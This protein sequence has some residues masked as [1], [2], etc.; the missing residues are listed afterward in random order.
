MP[1]PDV[2]VRAVAWTGF[3]IAA[4]IVVVVCAVFLLLHLWRTPPGAD[5]LRANGHQ[6]ADG[7]F[8]H[9]RVRQIHEVDGDGL[10]LL[11]ESHVEHTRPGN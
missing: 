8:H 6:F 1:K 4:A 11:P 5:R 3:S 10:R 7:T 2:D 9:H